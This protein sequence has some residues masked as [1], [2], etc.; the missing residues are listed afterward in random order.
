MHRQARR[1][2]AR[3]RRRRRARQLERG[4]PVDAVERQR[5]RRQ[6]SSTPAS[7]GGRPTCE[8]APRPSGYSGKKAVREDVNDAEVGAVAV[9]GDHQVPGGVPARRRR[10]QQVAEPAEAPV[11]PGGSKALRT[12]PKPNASTA[13]RRRPTPAGASSTAPARC[14][15]RRPCARVEARRPRAPAGEPRACDADRGAPERRR[16]ASRCRRG[17]RRL[18][19]GARDGARSAMASSAVSG[20]IVGRRHASASRAAHGAAGRKSQAAR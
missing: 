4:Q 5:K 7:T 13:P 17:R 2:V 12:G 11:T 9:V 14:R 15:A 16:S 10:R 3:R 6:D 8:I 18:A 20:F 19:V 1:L